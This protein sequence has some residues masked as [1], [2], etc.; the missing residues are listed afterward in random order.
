[1]PQD[2]SMDALAHTGTTRDSSKCHQAGAIVNQESRSEICVPSL[3]EVSGTSS[4]LFCLFVLLFKNFNAPDNFKCIFERSAHSCP[5]LLFCSLPPHGSRVWVSEVKIERSGGVPSPCPALH[6]V[7]FSLYLCR[8]R[9]S[10]CS[11]PRRR[12]LGRGLQTTSPTPLA[13]RAKVCPTSF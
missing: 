5:L 3:P 12:E 11:C 10:S 13:S 1:M 7:P 8:T 2:K 9:P 6:H 4:I